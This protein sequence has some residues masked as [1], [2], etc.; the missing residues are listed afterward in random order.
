[1]SKPLEAINST[2]K[3]R[4]ERFRA[5]RRFSRPRAYGICRNSRL[6][7]FPYRLTLVVIMAGLVP[8]ISL[9]W[10]CAFLIE[11]AGTSPAM[12]FNLSGNSSALK[13][14]VAKFDE[15]VG[16]K[17]EFWYFDYGESTAYSV[18]DFPDEIAAATA[19]VAANAGGFARVTFRPLLSAEDMDKALAKAG[20][21]RVP[22][23]Q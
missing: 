17:V 18:V 15:S 3:F 22:Q 19:Q 7:R 23:Q 6:E 12:T 20:T 21:I 5:T 13:A 4:R 1:M 9:G 11:I 14:A 10:H 8:A 16:G 2:K